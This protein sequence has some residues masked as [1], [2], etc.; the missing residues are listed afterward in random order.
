MAVRTLI[1]LIV[2]TAMLSF[3]V[4]PA[5]AYDIRDENIW[6]F[7]GAYELAAGERAE[8][9]GFTVKVYSV[10][11]DAAEPS[12]IVLVYRNKDFK[13]SFLM[14]ASANSEQGYDDELKINVLGIASGVVSLE[15]YKQKYERVWITSV[16]KTTMKA[17]GTLEDGNYRIRVKEVGKSGALVS[18]EG[19]EGIFEETYQSG[20]YRKFQDGVMVR[21]VYINPETR[22][23]S[24]ET[25]RQGAPAV[26]IEALADKTICDS[27]EDISSIIILTNSGTVPLHG[28]ILTTGS[29]AGV[30]GEPQLQHAMLDPLK[31]KKFIVPITAPVTPVAR[32]MLIE[33]GITGYDSKGSAYSNS[34]S[35]EVQVRPYVSVDKRVEAVG[36]V[37]G[38]NEM[39]TDGYFRITLRLRNTAGFGTI[40]DVRDELPSS[41]IPEDVERTQ[42][43]VPLDAGA[44]KEITYNAKPTE[45]GSF[46]F[47][48]AVAQ[49]EDG[50]ET[51]TVDSEPIT[52]IFRVRGSKVIV[53]KSIASG[54]LYAGEVTEIVITATNAG[55]GKV[56]MILTD[57]VPEG[58][59][60]MSG[61]VTWEGELEAGAS[62]K[63]SY[64]V[65]AGDIGTVRLPAA[66]AD[67]TDEEGKHYTAVSD[68]PVIYIDDAL[69]VD[70]GQVSNSAASY[71]AYAQT[72]QIPGSGNTE[73]TRIE[74]AGFML[75]AFITLFSLLA[76][77]PAIMYL[78]I[79]GMYK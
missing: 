67:C 47:G 4:Y 18:I 14:D 26:K 5:S 59:S 7:Q 16:P 36:K 73:L 25:F 63:I 62:K 1:F 46:T 68:T 61:Q 53:E 8:L 69:S 72:G 40:L 66:G 48:P 70:Q 10:D 9:E 55:T 76:I 19:K 32:N 3:V 6:I 21:V 65:K 56:S 11:M 28:I 37:S 71:Q 38:A 58:L 34:A 49:W 60:L 12:A 75:S 50:G 17:G 42:W 43:K 57:R 27:N 20:S 31:V 41:M 74:A 35:F 29:S 54:Y 22:E 2:S 77:I 13:R 78:F 30:V 24:I 33:S 45:S 44:T 51:Y 23:V 15:T 64:V 79:R 39:E 52:E